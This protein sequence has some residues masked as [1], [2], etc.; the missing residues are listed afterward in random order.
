M[1]ITQSAIPA[2]ESPPGLGHV[3]HLMGDGTADHNMSRQTRMLVRETI[4]LP[5]LWLTWDRDYLIIFDRISSILN[6]FM[7][8][9][10]V[11]RSSHLIIHLILLIFRHI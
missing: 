10:N 9:F 7:L 5:R 1:M 4:H 11:Y 3:Q 2:Q 8:M 6:H